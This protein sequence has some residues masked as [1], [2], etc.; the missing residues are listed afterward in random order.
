M[1]TTCVTPISSSLDKNYAFFLSVAYLIKWL[2]VRLWILLLKNMK[3]KSRRVWNTTNWFLLMTSVKASYYSYLMLRFLNLLRLRL[4]QRPKEPWF[5]LFLI[6][7][8]LRKL[9]KIPLVAGVGLLPAEKSTSTP[10]SV[11]W[12]RILMRK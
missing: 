9:P 2:L 5:R 4:R 6:S 3:L 11:I 7:S 10:D 12:R 1:K 8:A